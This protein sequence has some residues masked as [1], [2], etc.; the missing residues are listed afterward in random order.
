[1]ISLVTGGAGFIGS[2]L[3]DALIANGDTVY[4]VD[5]L[6]S[7]K[8]ENVNSEAQFV[9]LDFTTPHFVA[10]VCGTKPDI[11]Y[12]V[13]AVPR[14]TY[15][16]EHPVETNHNNVFGTLNVLEAARTAGV[17]KVVYSASSSAYGGATILP[18]PETAPLNPKSPYAVQK[19]AGEL[20]CS[21]YA[22]VYGLDTVA[23]R[24]FNV[25]GP[26]QDKDSPYTGVVAVFAQQLLTNK[27]LTIEGDG[28]QSRDFT[29]VANVVQANV[30]AGL[31]PNR[32]QGRV[33]NVGCNDSVSVRSI[34]EKMTKLIR[35]TM[36]E[37]R[38][39][40]RSPRVGDVR[41][42]Q[43]DITQITQTIGYQPTVTF[44]QGLEITCKWYTQQFIQQNTI[45]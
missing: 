42:S 22:N 7:G 30:K 16:V 26:R 24:Y 32:L 5:N 4:V 3:V 28:S 35:P 27:T 31:Y 39:E 13:G 21:A 37:P 40:F 33:F 19:L 23:L 43:A 14:V 10:Y 45:K 12:H 36:N 20:Y 6:R 41:H 1:M 25:F 17:K 38:I 15:S 9:E 2:H 8:I 34:A 44:D 29:F 18:T 11:I